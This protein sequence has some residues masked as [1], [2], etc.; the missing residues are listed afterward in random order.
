MG[1]RRFRSPSVWIEEGRIE[2]GGIE[3]GWIDMVVL[4]GGKLDKS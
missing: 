1:G 4:M 3:A 2:P